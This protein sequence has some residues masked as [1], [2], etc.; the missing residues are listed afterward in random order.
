MIAV[1]G[2]GVVGLASAR[3]LALGGRDVVLLERHRRPGLETSTHNSGVIHAGLYHPPGSLKSAL[4]V[5]GRERLY[6][7]AAEHRVPHVQCG[8]LIVANGAAEE[9]ALDR[10]MRNASANGAAVELVDAAFLRAREPRVRATRAM[11]SPTTGWIEAEAYVH[12]LEAELKRL[13]VPVLVGTPLVGCESAGDHL[14]LVTPQERIDVDAVVNAGGLYADEISRVCGGEAFTIYPCRGEY[15]ELA[16]RARGMVNGLVYPVPHASG[17]G[18]GVHLTRTMSGA[19]WIGPTIEYREGK[20]DYESGRLPLDAFLE[21][22]RELLPDVTIEDLR[23]GGTGI[24][25]KLHPPEQAFA[26]FMI[27]R[28]R[29][30]PRV[31]QAAGID[32]PGLTASLAIGELVASLLGG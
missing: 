19:V 5:G 14:V 31:I 24:R 7:F 6:A 11:W 26:D 28:D 22:T 18:L 16:P 13:D 20:D 30:Q 8:K 27:R 1:I 29:Q 9:S 2:G 3:A 4:C 15:A 23:L 17:H 12:A 21:P 32:S 25:A 10:L